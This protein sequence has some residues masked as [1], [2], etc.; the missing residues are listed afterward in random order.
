MGLRF[1]GKVTSDRGKRAQNKEKFSPAL[2]K[3]TGD[4]ETRK[5]GEG[6]QG[7]RRGL[8]VKIKKRGGAGRRELYMRARRGTRGMSGQREIKEGERRM[9]LKTFRSFA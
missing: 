3:R 8:G 1:V 7:R 2:T 9:K 5:E 4:W 6:S